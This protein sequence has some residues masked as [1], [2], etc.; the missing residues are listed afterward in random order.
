[1]FGCPILGAVGESAE[2]GD[3]RDRERLATSTEVR[4]E[5]TQV[6]SKIVILSSMDPLPFFVHSM[7]HQA[8]GADP[9]LPGRHI[10]SFLRV[11]KQF[12]CNIP[13]G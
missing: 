6:M 4:F 10:V 3:R 8:L 12:A 11:F 13:R 7:N 9:Y 2:E 1:M 5:R